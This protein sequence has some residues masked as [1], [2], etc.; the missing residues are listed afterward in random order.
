M[1]LSLDRESNIG[2]SVQLPKTTN[3]E[4]LLSVEQGV[5]V[6][7]RFVEVSRCQKLTGFQQIFL[8][9]LLNGTQIRTAT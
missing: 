5:N 3:G 9:F 7:A 6:V 4:Q 2:G 1:K 8:K